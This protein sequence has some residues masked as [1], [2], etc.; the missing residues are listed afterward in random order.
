M[1]E[2]FLN[3]SSKVLGSSRSIKRDAPNWFASSSRFAL[4]R[5]PTEK[6]ASLLFRLWRQ[7]FLLVLLHPTRAGC[8][9]CS[10][11]F[12]LIYFLLKSYQIG[13]FHPFHRFTDLGL[14]RLRE[15]TLHC[16]FLYVSTRDSLLLP[17][18]AERLIELDKGKAL[19]ELRLDEIQFR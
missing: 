12:P 2:T 3:A 8:L 13:T 1:L 4:L 10:F 19:I 5:D 16:S 11:E 6:Y 18:S 14:R 17:S 15:K 7:V 9:N